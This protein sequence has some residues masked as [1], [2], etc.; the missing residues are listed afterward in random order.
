MKYFHFVILL[1]YLPVFAQKN[2]TLTPFQAENQLFGFKNARGKVIV[3]PVFEQVS[4][5]EK[6]IAFVKQNR[7]W[8]ILNDKGIITVSP[9]FDTVKRFS[10]VIL[11][12]NRKTHPGLP[13]IRFSEE[14]YLGLIDFQGKTVQATQFKKIEESEINKFTFEKFTEWH[15]RKAESDSIKVVFATKIYIDTLA[16]GFDLDTLPLDTDWRKPYKLGKTWGFIDSLGL[17]RISN[18]YEAVEIFSEQLAAVKFQG[19][20]G[21]INKGEQI[22]VQP[23]YDFVSRFENGF[24]IARKKNKYGLLDK[25]GKETSGFAYDSIW[26][27]K[28]GVFVMQKAGKQGLLGEKGYETIAARFDEILPQTDKHI[29]VRR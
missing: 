11:V 12:G 16:K 5:F 28:S 4:T 21:F 10:E 3:S 25:K 26:A 9:Q 1:A 18:R 8:G 14:I 29:I 17:M 13:N 24:S 15:I 2:T 20:W 6:G 7:K 27:N 23:N 19:H 22:I